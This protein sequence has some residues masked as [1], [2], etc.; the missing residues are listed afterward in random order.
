MSCDK[1]RP[2]SN[3]KINIIAQFRAEALVVWRSS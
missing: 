2:R 3:A 1:N